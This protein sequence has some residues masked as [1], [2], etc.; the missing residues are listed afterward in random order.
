[1]TVKP[2]PPPQ[3]EVGGDGS[4]EVAASMLFQ[5]FATHRSPAGSIAPRAPWEAPAEQTDPRLK[6]IGLKGMQLTTAKIE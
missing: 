4:A 3:L 6:G 2:D 1:M 5:L